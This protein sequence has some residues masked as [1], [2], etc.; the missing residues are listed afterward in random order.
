MKKKL[1]LCVV[2]LIILSLVVVVNADDCSVNVNLGTFA[3]DGELMNDRV[4][5]SIRELSEKFNIPIKWDDDRREVIVSKELKQ[6]EV[7]EKTKIKNDGVIP[8]KDTAYKIGKILLEQYMEQQVEYTTKDKVYFLTVEYQEKD[9]AWIVS[10]QFEYTN[11]MQW[12]YGDSVYMP[13]IIINKNTGEVMY[14]N[15]YQSIED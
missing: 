7:S 4:Y 8:D 6:I 5:V 13:T 1:V 9:N 14:I 2:M 10:Q 12:T 15:T 3:L 11:G